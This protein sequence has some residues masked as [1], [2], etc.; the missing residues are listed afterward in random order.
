M[1]L[2]KHIILEG[3]AE[4]SPVFPGKGRVHDLGR[5]MDPQR[6]EAGGRIGTFELAVEAI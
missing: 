2:I 4:P 3:K 1:E 6:L 5:A